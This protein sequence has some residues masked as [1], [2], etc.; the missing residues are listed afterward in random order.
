[1]DNRDNRPDRRR[2]LTIAAMGGIATTFVLPSK[3][4]KPIIQTVVVPAHAAASAQ[5]CPPGTPLC[6]P[7]S[8][9]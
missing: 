4:A 1:M 6:P 7:F 8:P 9:T 5:F 2:I 3:W